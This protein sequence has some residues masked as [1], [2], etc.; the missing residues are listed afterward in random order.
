[1]LAAR[2]DDLVDLMKNSDLVFQEVQRRKQAIHLLLVNARELAVELRGVGEGQPGP[3]GAR[4]GGGRRPAV[5]AQR[6]GQGAEGDARTR[7]VPTSPSS[8]TS[9]APVRGSTPTPPT[10]PAI[11]TGE[12]LPGPRG[13]TSD[14]HCSNTAGGRVLAAVLAGVLLAAAST[15]S[16]CATTT[17]TK[18]VTAHFPRAVSIYVGSDVRILGVNVG[19]VTAVTP[20]GNSVRVDMEYD[21]QYDVPDR[22]QG[23]HRHPDPRRRPVRPAHPGV[24]RGRPG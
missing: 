17:E 24:R 20:E 1:M 5:A 9:S 22:R 14:E 19:R 3:D 21:A 11:P 13:G 8:A 4:A 15:S 7:S 10:W 12:F 18:T 6:Q 23:R 2:S 16:S